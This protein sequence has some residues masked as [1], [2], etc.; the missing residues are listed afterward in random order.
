LLRYTRHAI[1]DVDE[2]PCY[3]CDPRK[4]TKKPKEKSAKVKGTLKVI[5]LGMAGSGKS[6]FIKQLKILYSGF[7]AEEVETYK[8]ILLKNIMAGIQELVL[9]CSTL[10]LEIPSTTRKHARYFQEMPLLEIA[11]NEK[12]GKK[13]HIL[14]NDP[15][16][17]HALKESPRYQLQMT[18]QMPYLMSNLSRYTIPGFV[19]TNEDILR[20]RQSSTGQQVYSFVLNKI[21]WEFIDVGGQR[22]ERAKWSI[23]L[24]QGV[25]AIVWF[26]ALDEYNMKSLEDH[27]KTKFQISLEVWT[28]LINEKISNKTSLLLFLNKKDLFSDK[29]QIKEDREAFHQVFP[30]LSKSNSNLEASCNLVKKKFLSVKTDEK[31]NVFVHITNALDTNLMKD[32]FAEVVDNIFMARATDSGVGIAY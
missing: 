9:L 14:W 6:T 3:S 11:W 25:H 7:S 23:F 16:I 2:P 8:Q 15:C 20:A 26:Y 13:V 19:P 12:I 17:Q 28:E 10:K 22:P 18:P 31:R 1:P 5:S 4:S 29:L 27:T 32:V 21:R 24:E 30:G